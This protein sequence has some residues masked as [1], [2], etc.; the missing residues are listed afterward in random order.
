MGKN[1][2]TYKKLHKWPGLIISIV[3]LWYGFS[4]IIMNHREL[5]SG[6]DF[7]RRIMPSNYRYENWNNAALKGNLQIGSDSILVYG[8]IGI[9]LTDPAFTS[10]TQFCQ[11]FPKGIDNRKIFDVLKTPDGSPYA[12]AF[13]GLY[14]F[15]RA[16]KKWIKF[17]TRGPGKEVRRTRN[18]W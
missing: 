2:T 17:Q 13:S 8:N 12:A 3:L 7:N 6:I 11:G 14:G 9:W 4:G 16:N 10:Y 5:F 15:D 1:W 18:H